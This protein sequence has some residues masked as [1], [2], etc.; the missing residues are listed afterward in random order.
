VILLSLSL[1]LYH[2]TVFHQELREIKRNFSNHYP[3]HLN[4]IKYV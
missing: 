3:S 2:S 4:K 1:V